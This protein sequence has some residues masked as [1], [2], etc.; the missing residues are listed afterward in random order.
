[1][2]TKI[3]KNGTK[4]MTEKPFAVGG[5]LKP[6]AANLDPIQNNGRLQ[7]VTSVGK[8]GETKGVAPENLESL[9]PKG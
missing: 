9:R 2:E 4:E 3:I 8:R 1:M 7:I 5:A 6:V